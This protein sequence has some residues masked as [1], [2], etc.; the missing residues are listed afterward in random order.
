VVSNLGDSGSGSLR[1]SALGIVAGA[2]DGGGKGRWVAGWA[3]IGSMWKL[4]I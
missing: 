3:L 4:L 1:Q 2:G